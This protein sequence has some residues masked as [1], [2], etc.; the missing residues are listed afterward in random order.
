M[1]TGIARQFML[2]IV[3]SCMGMQA[4]A[5]ESP[6]QFSGNIALVTDYLYR[7]ISQTGEHPAVQGGMDYSHADSGFYV[8][9]W[10]S[11]LNFA[12]NLEIDFYGGLSGELEGGLSWDV[13]GLYYAY[14]GS[15]AQPE[16][17]F[18]EVYG[19]VGYTLPAAF[20]P[21]ISAGLAYSPDFFGEDGDAVYLNGG[22]E[23][24]L[25]YDFGVSFYLGWQDVAG[26]QTTGPDGFDY[27]HYSI[28][29]SKDIGPLSLGF[30]WND[31]DSDCG[32]EIC[33]ALV[34]SIA[35]S[36]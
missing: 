29:L 33:E 16:E 30:S 31:A 27:V 20:D 4:S 21:T 3:I 1:R 26:K 32:P 5:D 36:F 18:V 9:T 11:S 17:D 25:A 10:A 24:S 22:L 8:G 14:P 15:D 2:L 7:G 19:S 12:E 6:H 34:G 23:L 28:G 35:M 13:G